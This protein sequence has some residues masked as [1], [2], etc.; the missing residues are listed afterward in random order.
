MGVGAVETIQTLE[1][2]IPEALPPINDPF[3]VHFSQLN[4]G[5]QGE[6]GVN[7]TREAQF[8]AQCL[9]SYRT[10]KPLHVFTPIP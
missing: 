8:F 4:T 2:W 1:T 3:E 6:W 9:P 10:N 7:E 5:D